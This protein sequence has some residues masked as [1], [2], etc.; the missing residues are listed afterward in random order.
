MTSRRQSRANRNN[1]RKSTGPTTPQGKQKSKMNAGKHW[2]FA[3]QVVADH[4]DQNEFNQLL[5]V[6]QNELGPETQ[7]EFSI[8]ERFAA[9]LWRERR[10]IDAERQ[11]LDKSYNQSQNEVSFDTNFNSSGTP[12]KTTKVD[13]LPIEQQ[14][15]IG[16]YQVM[17][18][19]QCR[20]LLEELRR[21]QSRRVESEAIEGTAVKKLPKPK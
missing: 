6:L 19:N 18:T 9:T 3:K 15:L 2:I 8:V 21:E 16:R 7:I 12:A 14:I 1:A 4:E 5:R 10:L 11:W 13:V 17:L 20:G